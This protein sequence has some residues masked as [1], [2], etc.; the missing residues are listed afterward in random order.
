MHG[1][2]WGRV[3][4]LATALIAAGIAAVV[5]VTGSGSGGG[6]ASVPGNS[7]AVIDA[8]TRRVATSYPVGTTP[9]DV[10][11]DGSSIWTLNDDAQTISQVDTA[12][13]Q[14]VQRGLGVSPIQL[15]YGAGKLWIAYTRNVRPDHSFQVGVL[16]LDPDTLHELSR[17]FLPGRI[18][19]G[20]QP[21][22]MLAA[23][24]GVL[25]AAGAVGTACPDGAAAGRD[26]D[27]TR[28]ARSHAGRA[29]PDLAARDRPAARRQRS[30]P[31][32]RARARSRRPRRRS[33]SRWS[34]PI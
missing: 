10:A 14:S 9:T 20:A 15:A 2:R 18:E 4:L 7:V 6:H 29:R 21:G 12:T 30:D 28:V 22:H 25:V 8:V 31:A 13:G 5:V 23:L 16:E 24:D 26:V 17:V 34:A 1:R 3:A 27:G 11:A 33:R 32:R 19:A